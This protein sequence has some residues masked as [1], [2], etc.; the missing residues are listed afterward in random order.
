MAG[1]TTS[2]IQMGTAES[3]IQVLVFT[4]ASFGLASLVA[5]HPA[6]AKNRQTMNSPT[7]V[8]PAIKAP[9][10]MTTRADFDMISENPMTRRREGDYGYGHL[11][12]KP[13]GQEWNDEDEDGSTGEEYTLDTNSVY[14]GPRCRIDGPPYVHGGDDSGRISSRCQLEIGNEG[15]L[16][17]E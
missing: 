16:S 12:A 7:L 3:I 10:A 2:V 11:A 8:E 1:G 6:P 5:T 4:S 15:G 14:K 17:F 13:I 9:V